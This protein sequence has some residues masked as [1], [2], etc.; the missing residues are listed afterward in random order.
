MDETGRVGTAVVC[1][2]DPMV[3]RIVTAVLTR[4]GFESIV[5]TPLAS[6]AAR[7]V[8]KLHPDVVVLDITLELESGLDAIPLM[9]ASSPET[10][11]VVYSSARKGKLW[12]REAGAHFVI[13]KLSISDARGLEAALQALSPVKAS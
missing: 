13:D 1:D 8:A 10:T 4:C 11:I 9:R 2:D 7:L 5:G 12:A 3:R 6:E